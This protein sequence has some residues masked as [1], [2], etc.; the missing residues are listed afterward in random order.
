MFY[1]IGH[2]SKLVPEG[3]VRIDAVPSNVNLDSVAFLRPDNKIAAVLFNSG[4][5]DLDITLVDSVRGQFVVN[6]PAKSIH[7]LLYS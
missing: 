6:V 7:T 1:A 5:A 2:F 3:S 4:R